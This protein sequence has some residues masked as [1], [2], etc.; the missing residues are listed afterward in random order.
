MLHSGR[1]LALPTKIRLRWQG[2]PE[3]NALAYYENSKLMAVKSFITLM[4]GLTL[5][6]NYHYN[7]ATTVLPHVQRRILVF[8][9]CLFQPWSSFVVGDNVASLGRYENR[10]GIGHLSALSNSK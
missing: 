9:F 3:T 8:L 6:T 4:T 7:F 2:L 10:F 5:P 1:L